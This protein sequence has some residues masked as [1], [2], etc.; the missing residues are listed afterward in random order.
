MVNPAT[1]VLFACLAAR[2]VRSTS[3]SFVSWS[4]QVVSEYGCRKTV[5]GMAFVTTQ[6]LVVEGGELTMNVDVDE[7]GDDC[8]SPT[9]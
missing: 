6:Y 9:A 2:I 1:S 7:P 5:H 4:A 8:E 3:D